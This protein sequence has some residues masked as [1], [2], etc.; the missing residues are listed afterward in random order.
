[1]NSNGEKKATHS[2]N[3]KMHAARC[4]KALANTSAFILPHLRALSVLSN[5]YSDFL[6]R[7]H[8]AIQTSVIVQYKSKVCNCMK[9]LIIFISFFS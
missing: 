9:Q 4:R 6:E 1:M 5:S 2:L 8:I 3:G 7:L